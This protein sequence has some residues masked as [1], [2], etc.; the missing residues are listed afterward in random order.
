MKEAVEAAGGKAY[1]INERSFF[2]EVDMGGTVLKKVYYSKDVLDADILINMPIL[3][4]HS[5]TKVTIGL[6]NMMGLVWDRQ[7]FHSS[8]LTRAIA[9]LTAYKKPDLII[10]DA[11]RG[12]VDHGPIGP[13]TIKEWKQVVFGADPVAV[14]AYG[15]DLF[16]L[17]PSDVL[18]LSEASKLGIGEID[19]TKLTVQNV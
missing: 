4:H 19:I 10:M 12:I 7:Y 13:G 3:K 16:G 2:K 17:K 9:E 8:D 6:K 5:V 14:D 15:A 1:V 11:I 18:Y